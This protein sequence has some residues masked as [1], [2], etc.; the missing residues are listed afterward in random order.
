M[1][2][3]GTGAAAGGGI[4]WPALLVFEGFSALGA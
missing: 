2:K 1:A 4:L 3:G